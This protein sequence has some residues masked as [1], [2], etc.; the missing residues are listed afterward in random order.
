MKFDEGMCERGECEDCPMGYCERW[1]GQDDEDKEETESEHEDVIAEDESEDLE[2]VADSEAPDSSEPVESTNV[3][4]MTPESESVSPSV[5]DLEMK[6]KKPAPKPVAPTFHCE[7][8]QPAVTS[9]K[10]PPLFR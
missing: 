9:S 6:S 5:R 4:Q 10:V 2:A 3:S 7:S 8:P 1:D